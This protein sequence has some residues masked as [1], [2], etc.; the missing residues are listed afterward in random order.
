MQQRLQ[1][2]GGRLEKAPVPGPGGTTHVVCAPGMT[3]AEVE[4]K[5]KGYKG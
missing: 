3:R 1:Q 2:L 5:L 4:A